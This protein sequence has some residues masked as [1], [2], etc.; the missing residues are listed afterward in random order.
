MRP[1]FL[2]L[3][4]SMYNLYCGSPPWLRAVTFDSMNYAAVAKHIC[5]LA[6]P[7]KNLDARAVICAIIRH[8]E[9]RNGILFYNHTLLPHVFEY[10][11]PN[12]TA[13]YSSDRNSGDI[14]MPIIDGSCYQGS[15]LWIDRSLIS[16]FARLF[17]PDEAM[18]D[19]F[20][21][22]ISNITPVYGRLLHTLPELAEI[23]S[24][25]EDL[26]TFDLQICSGKYLSGRRRKP[27]QDKPTLI[28]LPLALRCCLD[29][30]EEKFSFQE[31]SF[32]SKA[33]TR[34]ALR[35]QLHEVN[36][37]VFPHN[38]LKRRL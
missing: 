18:I 26:D 6:A 1:S 38:L 37:G 20:E 3:R 10:A 7:W 23:S 32:E 28:L 24:R 9:H 35:H 12:K 15:P 36:H 17:E 29:F 2:G 21:V 16:P 31:L 33:S 8:V 11:F 25:K 14:S 34:G 5:A 19:G 13:P 30:L 22:K 27:A 4:Y